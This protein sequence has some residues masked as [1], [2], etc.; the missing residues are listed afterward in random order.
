MEVKPTMFMNTTELSNLAIVGSLVVIIS[1][2]LRKQLRQQKMTW[3]QIEKAREIETWMRKQLWKWKI[4]AAVYCLDKRTRLPRRSK[5]KLNSKRT[6]RAAHPY[7]F[8]NSLLG[9]FSFD[10]VAK[11]NSLH[12]LW[13]HTVPDEQQKI[14][15]MHRE[16][17]ERRE[18]G[19][20][21]KSENN[22]FKSFSVASDSAVKRP[23]TRTL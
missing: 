13:L 4:P 20:V 1:S 5:A 9:S 15:R 18:N 3:E 17:R 19:D 6:L 11:W 16:A 8:M 23:Q 2:L 7:I 22:C 14:H 10:L 21:L 12:F